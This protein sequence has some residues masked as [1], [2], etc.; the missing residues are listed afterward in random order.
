MANPTPTPTFKTVVTPSG[1]VRIA[2]PANVK[3][4]ATIP[5]PPTAQ[6][7]TRGIAPSALGQAQ[8]GISGQNSNTV[9]QN[10]VSQGG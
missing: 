7:S 6:T 8:T 10:P 4:T 2:P 1:T 3:T 9:G 5:K